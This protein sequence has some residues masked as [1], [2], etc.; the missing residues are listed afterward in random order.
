MPVTFNF[1]GCLT[2]TDYN[3]SKK[4]STNQP[5]AGHTNGPA[6]PSAP[7]LCVSQV[8]SHLFPAVL[9]PTIPSVAQLQRGSS[10]HSIRLLT[11]GLSKA[12]DPCL[13]LLAVLANTSP[14]PV[15][16]AALA[17]VPGRCDALTLSPCPRAA[18]ES[19]GA[20]VNVASMHAWLLSKAVQRE[21]PGGRKKSQSHL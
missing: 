11:P 13:H 8:T 6:G 12:P 3:S 17:Q 19:A 1:K 15:P 4:G 9:S 7:S 5:Q 2:A 18:W 20:T 21:P 14:A 16:R 10:L